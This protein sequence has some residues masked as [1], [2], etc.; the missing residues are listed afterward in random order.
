MLICMVS[1]TE[2]SCPGLHDMVP[3]CMPLVSTQT[4]NTASLRMSAV[5]RALKIVGVLAIHAR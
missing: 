5:S 2:P 3:V 4:F 1:K